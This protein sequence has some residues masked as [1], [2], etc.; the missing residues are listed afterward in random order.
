MK[1]GTFLLFSGLALAACRSS[2][3]DKDKNKD[4]KAASSGSDT[5]EEKKAARPQPPPVDEGIDVPTEE[6]FEEAVA[7]QITETS[8]LDKELNA[9]EKEIDK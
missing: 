4:D 6:N 9:L 8:D 7:T 3:K 2:D 5:A 1:L